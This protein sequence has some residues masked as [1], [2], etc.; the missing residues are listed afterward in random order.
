MEGIQT[1][2]SLIEDDGL[3]GS[4]SPPSATATAVPRGGGSQAGTSG[5]APVV[6]SAR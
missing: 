3:E 6:R 4:S 5:K 2:L 1:N